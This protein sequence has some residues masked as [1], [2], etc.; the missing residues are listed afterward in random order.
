VLLTLGSL[1]FRQSGIYTDKMSLW[2]DTV[3]KNPDSSLAHA[4]L[5]ELLFDQG[6]ITEAKPHLERALQLA[7]YLQKISSRVYAALLYDMGLILEK[8]NKFSDAAGYYQ[9]AIDASDYFEVAM[10]AHYCLAK[11]LAL[12]GKVEPAR[13]HFLRAIDIARTNNKDQMLNMAYRE[14]MLLNEKSEHPVKR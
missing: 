5:Y 4:Q 1:T 6:N 7:P 12:Q 11:I 10:N 3:N 8:Q 14:L 9:K 13:E 2:R